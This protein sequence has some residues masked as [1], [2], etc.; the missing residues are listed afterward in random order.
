MINKLLLLIL[1]ALVAGC[2]SDTDKQYRCQDNFVGYRNMNDLSEKRIGVLLGTT[3]D[4]YLSK[5]FPKA[6]IVRIDSQ[7]D[8]LLTLKGGKCDVIV[9]D[10]ESFEAMC[11]DDPE[12]CVL[13]ENIFDEQIGIGFQLGNTALRDEFNS[14]LTEFREDGT[15]DQMYKRWFGSGEAKPVMPT[16]DLPKTGTPLQVAV[17]S[18]SYPFDYYENG[19]SVGFDNE[20]LIRFGQRIGRPVRFQIINFGGLIAAISSG[21]VDIIASGITVTPE[22]AKNV[23]FSDSYYTSR[24]VGGILKKNLAGNTA[25]STAPTV[26]KQSFFASSSDSFYNNLIAEKRYVLILKGLWQTLVISVCA[27]LLGTMLGALICFMRMSKR[28]MLH[29]IAKSYITLM[30][31]IPVL[32]LLMLLYYAVFAKWDISATLVAIIT[33]AL[34]FAAYVSEMFRTSI[35]GVDRGQTEAGI[36]LGFTKVQT[37]LF[38]VMPQAVKS[39]LPV[40]KG[41]L[42]SLVKMTSIVGY[43]AVEDLTKASD[44]IRSRTF[45]AFFP[46]VMVAIIYFLLAWGFTAILDS[47]NKKMTSR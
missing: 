24:A 5:N 6:T 19:Q 9:I 30:R 42:I 21:K 45:D 36:A 14:M 37:F 25:T 22:R 27:A 7:S 28:V 3:H 18:T 43:I 15:Y 40:Y 31:G 11:K 41:E 17:S 1:L 38:I 8:M 39:V 44:I 34:N 4:A 33:F 46:L 23:A 16:L 20:L 13:D 35:Q 10:G 12:V 32:V 26:E 2:S 47:I 29:S